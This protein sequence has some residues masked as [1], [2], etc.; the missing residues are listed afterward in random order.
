M[1][2]D[3]SRPRLS[4]PRILTFSGI[5]SLL[6]IYPLLWLRVLS[7]PRQRTAADFLPFYAAGGAAV[8]KGFASAYDLESERQAEDDV[9]S[10][11]IQQAY[12]ARGQVPPQDLGPALTMAEVNPFPH[13][14]FILPL[15]FGLAHLGYVPAFVIWSLLM[16]GL[17]MLGCLMLVRLVPEAQGMDR[18]ILILGSALF[19]PAFFSFINGQDSAILFVGAVLWFTGLLQ[20]RDLSSGL[21]LALTTIRP[22][23][24]LALALPFIFRHRK[25][26]WWFCLGA[27]CLALLSLVLLGKAGIENYLHILT[28]SASGSGFKFINDAFHID[29][30]GLLHR[31]LPWLGSSVIRVVGWTGF[32]IAILFLCWTW[33]RNVER[34]EKWIGL[35]VIVAI[36]FVPH[37]NYHDLVLLLLPLYG[38]MRVLLDKRLMRIESVILLPLGLSLILFITYFFLPSMKYFILY[39]IMG[40]LLVVL[41]FPE[42]VIFW[43]K[44]NAEELMR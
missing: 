36:F 34:L 14:P 32:V 40:L 35:A 3:K 19:F 1:R 22:Q 37:F 9:L 30:G 11:T 31:D 44:K 12:L 16:I 15:L 23:V 41:W 21:G 38:S 5:A 18:W 24:A 33:A 8:T 43:Q 20:R 26:W 2:P 27:G 28:L 39:P 13:P 29:L 17:F 4:L 7:D 10:L 42:K 6:L 25:V